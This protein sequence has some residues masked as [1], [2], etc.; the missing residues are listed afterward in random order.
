MTLHPQHLAFGKVLL[1][2]R[3]CKGIYLRNIS[4]SFARFSVL[5]PTVETAE[6]S[7]RMPLTVANEGEG[8][9]QSKVARTTLGDAKV[10]AKSEEKEQNFAVKKDESEQRPRQENFLACFE[11]QRRVA[12][13]VTKRVELQL[14]AR[15]PGKVS[16]EVEIATQ[17]GKF[18]VRF[19][20]MVIKSW[21]DDVYGGGGVEEKRAEAIAT[22]G[23]KGGTGDNGSQPA[24]KV[25]LHKGGEGTDKKGGADDSFRNSDSRTNGNHVEDE[26]A[27]QIQI[28][29][30]PSSHYDE[31]L[32]QVLLD[33][34]QA[35]CPWKLN[36]SM[37]LEQ[38]LESLGPD[39][40][41]DL[42]AL[43]GELESV[44]QS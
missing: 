44:D 18:T 28:P 21:E 43:R 37:T 40:L 1:G 4:S 39:Y 25:G 10:E 11:E 9:G 32:D 2:T 16:G 35:S 12:P 30:F 31:V 38:M 41:P 17:F 33:E 42:L 14:I 20:G 34:D 6:L 8:A 13:G 15:K 36:P 3:R 24:A 26:R 7:P 5:Q 22:G 19:E 29:L 23:A 27:V